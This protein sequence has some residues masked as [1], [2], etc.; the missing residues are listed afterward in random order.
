MS[1]AK[2]KSSDIEKESINEKR[3]LA[4]RQNM[5]DRLK[6][7]KIDTSSFNLDDGKNG[8]E[9]TGEVSLCIWFIIF[10]ML[11]AVN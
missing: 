11:Y 6:W 2:R 5:W 10:S 4:H 8:D 3:K 1:T 7:R 9:D